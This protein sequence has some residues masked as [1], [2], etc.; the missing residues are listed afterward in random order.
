MENCDAR[1]M[2]LAICE[3]LPQF[4]TSLVV[5]VNRKFQREKRTCRRNLQG[6]LRSSP[7][8]RK[9][10]AR[11]LQNTWLLKAQPLSSTIRRAKRAPT[12]W[13]PRSAKTEERLSR[14]RPT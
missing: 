12:A 10:S 13:L 14:C 8:H 11:R 6:R 5:D 3:S 9:E 7:E 1:A 4:V 2:A